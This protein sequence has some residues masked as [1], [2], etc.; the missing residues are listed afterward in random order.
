MSHK[1]I[2]IKWHLHVI[3]WKCSC[4]DL[5]IAKALHDYAIKFTGNSLCNYIP[6]IETSI[7]L[8]IVEHGKLKTTESMITVLTRWKGIFSVI[9]VPLSPPAYWQE[10]IAQSESW[11]AIWCRSLIKQN[12]QGQILAVWTPVAK[13]PSTKLNVPWIL[14]YF[15]LLVSPLVS[16]YSAIGDTISCDAPYSAIGFRGKLFLRYPP[17]LACLLTAIGHLQGK[18][19]GCSSDSLRY[20]RKHCATGVLLHL[21]RDRGGYFGRVTKVSPRKMGSAWNF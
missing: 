17:F 8:K 4:K 16:H 5:G 20:H 9:N 3:L 12:A 1:L 6:Q 14:V 11:P 7:S 2:L 18:K 21:S 15:W 13:L 19:W 10:C